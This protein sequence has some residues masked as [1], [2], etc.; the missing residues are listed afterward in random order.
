MAPGIRSRRLIGAHGTRETPVP[1]PNTE[2]K[3]RSGYN[4][5]VIKPWENS[6]V[7]NYRETS[8]NGW[9]FF[10]IRFLVFRDKTVSSD[11]FDNVIRDW[12]IQREAHGALRRLIVL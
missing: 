12:L 6:T 7:P 10:L 8:L 9:F 5:W 2:V 3:P 11:L 1:I 4:T